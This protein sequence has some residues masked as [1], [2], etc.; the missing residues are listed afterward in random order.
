MISP[1]VLMLIVCATSAI[2]AGIFFTCCDGHAE[3]EDDPEAA[4]PS[5]HAHVLRPPRPEPAPM[6]AA[7]LLYHVSYPRRQNDGSTEETSRSPE[8]DC[9]I[10]LGPMEGGEW[11][12]VM[13]G[14]RHE[15]HRA[16]IATWLL[17]SNTTCPLCRAHL[18]WPPAAPEDMV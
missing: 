9:A 13:P 8:E 2:L 15:F 1:D 7:A 3:H 10:C 18:H 16:C 12:S 6:M 11:C 14:C 17:A 5:S 4:V